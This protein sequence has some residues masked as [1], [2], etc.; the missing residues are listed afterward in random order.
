M[1]YNKL[2]KFAKNNKT[3]QVF[4]QTGDYFGA[5]VTYIR[6]ADKSAQTIVDDIDQ[7]CNLKSSP[8]TDEEKCS[9]QIEAMDYLQ[10]RKWEEN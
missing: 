9:L 10:M 4:I 3:A 6:E 5:W 1:A 7:E 2:E 8:L